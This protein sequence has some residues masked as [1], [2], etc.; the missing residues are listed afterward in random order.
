MIFT[1]TVITISYIGNF[2]SPT[3]NLVVNSILGCPCAAP[4]FMFCMGVGMVYTRHK[5]WNMMIKRGVKLLILGIILN[6]FIYIIPYF[7]LGYA[8]GNYNIVPIY[9]G[10]I[11]FFV[12]ILAFAGLSFI[13]MGIFKKFE[14]SNKYLLLIA[15]LL[16]IIGSFL[17]NI[18]FG[19][20]GLNFLLGY[21][22][23]TKLEFTSFPFFN[24]FIIPV[25][26]YIWGTYFIRVKDKSKLFRFWPVLLI[27][28]L[29]YFVYSI[30]IPGG[31]LSSEPN[32][33]YY[34]TTFDV[35]SCLIYIHGNIGFCY[36]LS[37][38]LPNK[39][40]KVFA[41]LSSNITVIYFIQWILI[42]LTLI[43]IILLFD[44]SLFNDLGLSSISIF[45]LILSTLCATYYKKLKNIKLKLTSK[46]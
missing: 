2:I 38:F 43:F 15:V 28:S 19:D 37:K 27:V 5:Q 4:V 12:D 31:F 17:R 40:T 10:L 25:V 7:V 23:G 14:L 33:Y 44:Y 11:L 41:V 13:F 21:F 16:S 24:W 30:K 36:Y 1:H 34:M 20:P 32:Y 42:P 9:G 45:I 29:F 26:G 22:I 39:I 3:Y 18:T 35:I 6:V 8:I 46:N